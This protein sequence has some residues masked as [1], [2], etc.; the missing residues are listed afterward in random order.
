[1]KTIPV[2]IY[3]FEELEESVQE[4][5]IENYRREENEYGYHWADEWVDSLKAFCDLFG[6]KIKDYSVGPYS[7]SYVNIERYPEPEYEIEGTLRYW[8]WFT[9]CYEREL[10]NF[11]TYWNKSYTKKRVSKIMTKPMSEY[12]LTGFCADYPIM[13]HIEEYIKHPNYYSSA[14]ELFQDCINEWINDFRADMEYQD[15]DEYIRERLIES[16]NW[17]YKNGKEVCEEVV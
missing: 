14:E 4:S 13:K 1:M 11:K 10:T 15:N 2:N 3:R 5:I 8:K 16:D 12:D 9:N 6:L 17:Y 7:Y